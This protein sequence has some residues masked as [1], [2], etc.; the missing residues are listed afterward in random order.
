MGVERVV[1]ECVVEEAPVAEEK[2]VREGLNLSINDA[3]TEGGAAA[4]AGEGKEQG[5]G[6]WRNVT[7][8]SSRRR[9][10]SDSPA[11]VVR[12]QVERAKRRDAVTPVEGA[13]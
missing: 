6:G 8:R 11:E 3:R 1:V 12:I 5:R 13:E 7:T 9:V 4:M 2:G 10:A